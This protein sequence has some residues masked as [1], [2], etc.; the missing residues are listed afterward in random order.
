MASPESE[1][2]STLYREWARRQAAEFP[3]P[4]D[5]MR[6][7]FSHWGDVT[8]EPGGV[9]Y[10]EVDVDGMLGL[11]IVPKG[12]ATDTVLLCSHGGGYVAGSVYTHRKFFAHVAKQ[13][14][15]R[16]LA[17]EYALCPEQT[18][19]AP[20]QDMVRAYR[21]LT[22]HEG[23]RPASVALIGDSAG[24]S[25]A[26]TTVAAVRDAGLPL[27]AATVPLSPWAGGDTSGAS[28]DA[29]RD[30]DVL[31]TR[32]MSAAI[33][34]IFL[35][36]S[37]PHD[38][39]ANPLYIDYAGYPP[40]YIQVGGHE[41]VLDDSTRPAAAAQAAGVDVTIDIFPEMQHCFQLMAGA[42]PEADDAV[43]RIAAWLRAKLDI[44]PDQRAAAAA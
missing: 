44:Q 37:D 24:G 6:R 39:L 18:H 14:G 28:Y 16:A 42:A 5:E 11:W 34:G 38:P 10:A 40:I 8:A 19:P 41:A 35:G 12:A 22:G 27:P 31:V 25:L 23:I 3:M 26:L 36:D 1:A 21:W 20:V 9:D 2:L 29:N 4:I 43:A 30:N 17:V 13:A 15:C 33:G 7:M 32:E